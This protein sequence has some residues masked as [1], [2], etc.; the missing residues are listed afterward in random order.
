MRCAPSALALVLSLTVLSLP[1]SAACDVAGLKLEE[2]IAQSKEL[3]EKA[4]AQIVRDLRTLRDA[5]VV[6]ESYKFDAECERLVALVRQLSAEPA[7]TIERS[8]DTDE[9]K[10]EE[11]EETRE[12]KPAPGKK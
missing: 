1:A 4:N 10:A 11:I 7:K 8:G 6:L 12:P 5:A 2:A 9:D 3:R